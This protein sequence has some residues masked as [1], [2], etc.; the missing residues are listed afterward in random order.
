MKTD[1]ILSILPFEGIKTNKLVSNDT[2]NVILIAIEKGKELTAHKSNTDASILVLEGEIIFKINGE[3]HLLNVH[4]MYAF[5][6]EEIHAVEA[7]TNAKL[8][9]IK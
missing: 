2:G 5:K 8:I 7:I 3:N 1:N 4:D 6:A 9:L